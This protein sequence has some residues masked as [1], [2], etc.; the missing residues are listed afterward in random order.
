MQKILWHGPAPILAGLLLACGLLA[1]C[2]RTAP[3]KEKPPIDPITQQLLY[4]G[5]EALRQHAFVQ[6]LALADSAAARSPALA[7]VPFLRGRIYA[8]LARLDKAE[9]YYREALALRPDYPG[10]WHNLGNTAYRQQQYSEAIRDYRRELALNPDPRPWRGIGQA[11]VELGRTDSA[12]YAFE[13]A[14]ALDSTFA[15]AHFGL[16]LLLDDL[17]DVEGALRAAR[18]ALAH[19]PD[20]PEYRYHVGAYLVKLGRP[21]EAFPHL[22]AVTDVWPWHQ[23]AHYNL[24]QA[25]MRLGQAAEARA[26]LDRAE[27]LRELQAQISHHENTA[28]VQPTD[29]Y[30]HAG[31]G[32]LLR[33]AGRYNDAM[34][35]YRV[36]LYLD[37]GNL[38]I[39]N[40]VAVLHLLRKDTTAAIQ[41]FEEIVR[42]DS[43]YVH[44]WVNLGSLYALS[45]R[46]EAAR[47]AWQAA[48]RADPQNEPARRL[49]ASLPSVR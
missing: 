7:D 47:A 21:D 30:A 17:G 48:L 16:A 45:G 6:A 27:Q 5:S 38:E 8:E 29:P 14:L 39:R 2:G 32:T 13:Q 22:Q 34:H 28:R 11:Y 19:A 31:L 37:P 9:A 26:M 43:A 33:R 23:G 35:A 1:A 44:A 40:N 46:P 18:R 36:A 24:G 49:L 20:S 15:Q 10:A 12:R 41:A 4:G 42:A 3:S 25:L